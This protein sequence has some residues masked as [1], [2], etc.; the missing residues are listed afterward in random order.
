MRVATL[1][2]AREFRR[3]HSGGKASADGLF[4]L[5]AVTRP[6]SGATLIGVTVSRKVGKAVTR[7]RIRRR[8]LEIWRD[9][10]TRGLVSPG[11]EIVFIARPAAEAGFAEI[12]RSVMKLLVRRGI[13]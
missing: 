13:I 7:N 2:S 5:K 8:V 12:R 3:V 1:K 10:Y 4:V 11:F 6:D 9:L